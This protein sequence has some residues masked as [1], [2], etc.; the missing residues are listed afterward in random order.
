MYHIVYKT[1]NTLN[2]KYYIGVHTTKDLNDGYL[3]SGKNI[4]RAVKKYGKN[5]FER[6]I[7]C[8]FSD[9]DNALLYEKNVVTREITQDDMCYNIV[10]GGGNPPSKRGVVN[11]KTKLRGDARTEAQKKASHSRRGKPHVPAY[12][13]KA[14][15]M[16]NKSFSSITEAIKF[17]GL[18]RSH[19]YFYIKNSHLNIQ[20]PE[21]LKRAS[22][23]SR[24]AKISAKRK[25]TG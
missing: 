18:S 6:H 11:A 24:N 10:E 12:N 2:G 25:N 4:Q 13:R 3:G 16:F 7:L 22:W 20:T 15:I 9:R 21:D 23:E 1:I 5:V 17:F 14:V 8:V 19:Y